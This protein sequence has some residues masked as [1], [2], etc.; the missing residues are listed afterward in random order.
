M[1]ST[2]CDVINNEITVIGSSDKNFIGFVE[3]ENDFVVAIIVFG[4]SRFEDDKIVVFVDDGVDF[5]VEFV[6]IVYDVFV[7]DDFG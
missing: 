6:E 4:H 2:D 7:F 3:F 5:V 1:N